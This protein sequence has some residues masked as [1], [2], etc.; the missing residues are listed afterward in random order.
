MSQI[1]KRE[2]E[3]FDLTGETKPNAFSE[4]LIKSRH[5]DTII[6]HRGEWSGGRY[7][8]AAMD[9]QEN[10]LVGLVQKRLGPKKFEYIAQ[11]THKRIK[12]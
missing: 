2:P 9:A 3:V 1:S 4:A 11:R 8:S 5:G 12:K 7:K 6:Y 10:G